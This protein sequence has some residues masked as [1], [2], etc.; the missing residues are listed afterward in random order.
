MVNDFHREDRVIAILPSLEGNA[1]LHYVMRAVT[2]GDFVLPPT[3]TEGMYYPERKVVLAT[4]RVI[5]QE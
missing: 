3:T 4:S 1:V 2:A 5:V